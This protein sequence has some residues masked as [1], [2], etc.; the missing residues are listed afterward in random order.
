[1]GISLGGFSC[2]VD[3]LIAESGV[4]VHQA[5]D[6]TV[7][8]AP[9]GE[10]GKDGRLHLLLPL[11][12]DHLTGLP[13]A[14]HLLIPSCDLLIDLQGETKSQLIHIQYFQERK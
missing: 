5:Q 14:H 13:L 3:Y 7:D 8:A 1:M 11:L 12:D 4:S 6:V 10:L 2:G 9:R